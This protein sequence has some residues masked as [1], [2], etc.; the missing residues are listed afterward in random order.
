[1]IS[2]TETVLQTLLSL[3]AA[4]CTAPVI[5]NTALPEVIP[6]EGLV[7]IYDGD[8]GQS[9]KT[10]G[11]FEPVYYEHAI[12]IIL[13]VE[14]GD[15]GQRDT[16][17]DTLVAEVKAVFRNHPDLNG[18]V[19]GLT[20]HGLPGPLWVRGLLFGQAENLVLWPVIVVLDRLHPAIRQGA[21][22]R[23]NRPVVFLQEV[24]RH[25]VY[26]V[27]LGLVYDRLSR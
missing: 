24:F 16:T 10:L 17:F 7:I 15:S 2:K 13:F 19:F 5:R 12:D 23:F 6:P 20:H 26:G 27:T 3:L 22:P 4:G 8:P 21:L 18:T 1:M 9:D 25:V 14:Q 11:G